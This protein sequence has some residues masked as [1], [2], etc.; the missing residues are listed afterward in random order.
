M[1]TVDEIRK[2]MEVGLELIEQRDLDYGDH[3]LREEPEFLYQNI[4]RK[5]EGIK[6]LK[7]KGLLNTPKGKEQ[8]IDLMNYTA[9]Y[10]ARLSFGS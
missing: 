7:E 5:Y 9:M 2:I 6:N 8:L 10:Y 3:W 4:R 1:K